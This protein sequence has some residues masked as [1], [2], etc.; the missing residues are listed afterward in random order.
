[1]CEL[2]KVTLTVGMWHR[3]REAKKKSVPK[4]R[5]IR[6]DK[7][8]EKRGAL[9]FTTTTTTTSSCIALPYNPNSSG[10]GCRCSPP[11]GSNRHSDL[12]L[13]RHH[14][15]LKTDATGQPLVFQRSSKL[16]IKVGAALVILYQVPVSLIWRCAFLWRHLSGYSVQSSDCERLP[17]ARSRGTRRCSIRGVAVAWHRRGDMATSRW[18][19][20]WLFCTEAGASE[21][22]SGPSFTITSLLKNTPPSL[23]FPIFQSPIFQPSISTSKPWNQWRWY[24]LCCHGGVVPGS[25]EY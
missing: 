5:F 21:V 6:S 19:C 16:K 25:K 24:S 12:Q 11:W 20:C 2:H 23:P 9:K 7:R 15:R 18:T 8:K 13:R 1:M 4:R 10:G 22:Q 14:Q 3:S 17:R